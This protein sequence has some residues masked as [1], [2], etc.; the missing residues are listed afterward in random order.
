MLGT[1][2][3]QR[4]G[5]SN[6]EAQ[7]RLNEFGTNELQEKKKRT[8]LLM[9][10]D[11][12]KDFMILVLI[13]AAVIAGVIGDLA[14]TLVIIA[15]VI[16][17][18]IIGFV[19]EYR[20]EK[21]M[22]A[23]KKMAAH[24]ATVLREGAIARV[25]AAELVPGDVV[26]LEAG[27][28]VPADLRLMETAQLKAEEAA[29]TGES[30]SVEKHSRT[31]IEDQLPLAD[32]KNMVYKGTTISYGRGTGV[33][34]ATGMK[35]ELGK[36]ASMLQD[37]KEVKTPLQK[38]LA[39]FGR[40]LA[41]AVL[42]ICAIVFGMGFLRGEPVLLMLLTA[43]S[44]AVAAIPEAL[45]A[46]ITI[47]LALGAKKLVS[48]NA[49]VR[50]LP[51]VETLGSVTYICSD[52]TGTLTVNRMTVED[53]FVN[54][55]HL[56]AN[57]QSLT[58]LDF[59]MKGLALSNDVQQSG[60]GTLLGDPTEI[61]LQEIAEKTGYNK[62][63]LENSLPRLSEIPFDSE[64][65][66]MTTLHRL[67]AGDVVSFTKGATDVMLEKADTMWIN[68]ELLP[69]DRNQLI[70][71][72][73]E[74]A[75]RGLRV[76]CIAMRRWD[77]L[78]DSVTCEIVEIKLS[79]LGLVGMMDPPREEVKEAVNLCKTAGIR[80]V[81][82]TGDH[83]VTARAIAERVGFLEPSDHDN[84]ITGQELDRLS[85]QEFEEKVENIRV[86][87]R[88]APE[89]KLKIVKA[90]QDKGQFVAMTGDG[91]NDAPALKRADIGVAMG[92]TGTDVSKEAAHMILLDDN[93]ATIV[94]A[95]Q[96]GR[97]IYDNIRK[98]I[99][100]LLTTN[101]GEIWTLFLAPILGLPVPLLPIHLLWVNLVTDGLPALALSVEPAEGDVMK[102]PPRNPKESIFAHGL[103]LHA[104]W[105]GIL[106]G[107]IVLS[108]QAW[109]LANV[110]AHWQTMVF[111]V[112]CLTQLGH[113]L[114]IRSERQSL[115]KMGLFSNKPLL[116]AVV[117]T[118]LLQMA[119]IYIPAMNRIFKTE[120]LTAG[121]LLIAI[122]ASSIVFFAVEIGEMDSSEVGRG[123]K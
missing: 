35:T 21:A 34:T 45:P 101:S 13:G 22:E 24:T 85:L 5:I 54:G 87:A 56:K 89:Q 52:K 99:R 94:R 49:L 26:M 23:L 10:L 27:S 12:F 8:T 100:Y 98:F 108:I 1:L 97:K 31:L 60:E 106:M 28:L 62:S 118:F 37:E 30:V 41:L 112:L 68:G 20:A 51:A 4:T 75:E 96:E 6:T 61:A 114:A 77:A 38:R 103:G 33:V 113:V 82:I 44:L 36:I 57:D 78:P 11:Q 116:G 86:Y 69:I 7:K 17:N 50:K 79:I 48:K 107:V 70:T 29:L 9:F 19:Q 120:P 46:V 81:M 83:P 91:V 73:D 39:A 110:D 55:N 63:E 93:F 104:I 58:Q 14:D 90:L 84:V 111:T 88:V 123:R 47:S 105:V 66:C 2:G 80:P 71:A 92:I 121:E 122:A 16:I 65:K 40:K 64:R 115:F 117:L 53:F 102:R 95:V 25:A 15:I 32:R 67:P 42:V 76:L 74:M 119:I 18:A 109:S 43:I 3:S 59:L 72:N